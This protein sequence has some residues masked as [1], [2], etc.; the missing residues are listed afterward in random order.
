MTEQGAYKGYKLSKIMVFS[1]QLWTISPSTQVIIVLFLNP[2][3]LAPIELSLKGSSYTVCVDKG[4]ERG[5]L[6]LKIQ[7]ALRTCKQ[8]C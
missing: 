3:V 7:G 6:H 8:F 2:N 5:D 1:I 4:Q